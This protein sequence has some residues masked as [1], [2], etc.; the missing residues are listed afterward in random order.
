MKHKTNF[1]EVSILANGLEG[2]IDKPSN[3]L[4]QHIMPCMQAIEKYIQ[5]NQ[6]FVIEKSL[7]FAADDEK[8]WHTERQLSITTEHFFFGMYTRKTVRLLIQ[9][10]C[11]KRFHLAGPQIHMTMQEGLGCHPTEKTNSLLSLLTIT[12]LL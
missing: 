7:D 11:F 3:S 12:L 8:L 6:D 5:P 4:E 9:K 2:M 10:I 1:Q